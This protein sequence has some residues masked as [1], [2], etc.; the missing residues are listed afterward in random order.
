MSGSVCHT[1]QYAF[2]TV[3]FLQTTQ[4]YGQTFQI[5]TYLL[6]GLRPQANYTGRATAACR[7]RQ[8]Q[9]LRIEGATWSA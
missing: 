3:L 2:M 8:C 5:V 4:A 6:R 1:V 9:L 7:Q